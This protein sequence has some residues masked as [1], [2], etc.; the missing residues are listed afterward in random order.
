MQDFAT[1][2]G[3]L[4]L[5]IRRTARPEHHGFIKCEICDLKNYYISQFLFSD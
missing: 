2:N 5:M 4:F 1:Q 3:R